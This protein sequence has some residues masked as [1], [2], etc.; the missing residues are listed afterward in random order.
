MAGG[1]LGEARVAAVMRSAKELVEVHAE[2][3]RWHVQLCDWRAGGG[4]SGATRESLSSAAGEL[5]GLMRDLQ[6]DIGA[7]AIAEAGGSES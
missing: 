7:A 5:A 6:R 2:I 1:F 4:W 3:G